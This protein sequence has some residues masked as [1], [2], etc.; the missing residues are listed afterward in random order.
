V[1]CWTRKGRYGPWLGSRKAP[2]AE[3]AMR[4]SVLNTRQ[5]MR[6]TL[7]AL[8]GMLGKHGIDADARE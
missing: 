5:E 1:T 6:R 7:A 2:D 3:L 4:Q 8:D